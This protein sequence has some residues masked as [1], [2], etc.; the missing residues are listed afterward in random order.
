MA[1]GDDPV[2][3]VIGEAEDRGVLVGGGRPRIQI[4]VAPPLPVTDA[5]I[6]EAVDAIDASIGVVFD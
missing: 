6:D 1:S 2:D 5:D 4:I 3:D